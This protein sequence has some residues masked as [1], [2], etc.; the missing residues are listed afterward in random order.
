MR[1][2]KFTAIVQGSFIALTALHN[3][4]TVHGDIQPEHLRLCDEGDPI[5]LIDFGSAARLGDRD[6]PKYRG[7]LMHYMPPEIARS[8]LSKGS[9][10]RTAKSDIYSLA[11][12]L[13]FAFDQQLLPNYPRDPV[14]MNV[15]EV[16][17]LIADGNINTFTG[18]EDNVTAVLGKCLSHDPAQRPEAADALA[19]LI[20]G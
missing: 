16:L 3:A 6:A 4:R 9:A 5:Q 20:R 8:V 18:A 15:Q 19:M 14:Q 2:K 11:A 12:S 10:E 1:V 7:G 13:A 17:V